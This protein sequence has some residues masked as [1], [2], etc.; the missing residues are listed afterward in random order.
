MSGQ[1]WEL[2]GAPNA[3][4]LGGLVSAD[5]RRVR[6]GGCSAPRRLGRLT[7]EDMRCSGSSA[8]PACSICATTPRSLPRPPTGSPASR[9]WCACRCTTRRT[10]SSRTCRRC[11][12]A[13]T[14]R[15]RGL[16]RQGTPGAMAAIYRWFVTGEAARASFGA[17]VRLAAEPANLPLLFHCSAGKD[18]TGWLTVV[19]L[20]ALG[21][22]GRRSAPTTCG[23][24]SGARPPGG[25]L[26]AMRRRHPQLEGRGAAG[27]GGPRVPRR[28]LRRGA[29]AARLVRRVPAGRA[30][31]R[32]RGHAALRAQLLE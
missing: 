26:E 8:R 28:R 15:V 12:S 25:V 4:D 27:A 16:A 18:R 22:D 10:R 14:W 19:L 21:V 29:P 6:P 5:G 24:T 20:T 31:V 23:T 7:D 32:R 2:V 17:A 11:C 30:G 3:R 1:D 13:T 9:G